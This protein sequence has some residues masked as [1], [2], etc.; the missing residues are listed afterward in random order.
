LLVVGTG[1]Q[2]QATR[3]DSNPFGIVAQ[4]GALVTQLAVLMEKND[5]SMTLGGNLPLPA[6]PAIGQRLDPSPLVSP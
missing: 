4:H 5:K 3:I 2:V 1:A 6:V